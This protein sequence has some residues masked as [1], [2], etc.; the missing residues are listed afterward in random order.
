M[1][2]RTKRNR[3]YYVRILVFVSFFV[4]IAYTLINQQFSINAKKEQLKA[5]NEQIVCAESEREEL[6]EQL[7]TVNTPEYIEKVARH[8]LGYALPDEIVF[9]DASSKK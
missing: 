6:D 7:K 4:Y 5:I 8:E 1:A 9:V 3:Q 2:K